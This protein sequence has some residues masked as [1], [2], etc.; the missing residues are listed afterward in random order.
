MF[1][2]ACVILFTWGAVSPEGVSHFSE[3]CPIF[4][5]HP[6]GMHTYLEDMVLLWGTDKRVLV[7]RFISGATSADLTAHWQI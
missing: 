3:G 2:H 7:R 6:T 1:S 4:G 5:T